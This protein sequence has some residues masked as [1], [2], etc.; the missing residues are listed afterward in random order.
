M[1]KLSSTKIEQRALN[2]LESIIDKHLTMS[3]QFNSQDKEMSW[4]G[5]IDIFKINNGNQSK[6]N[7]DDRVPVQIKGHIDDKQRYIIKD[8][9]NYSVSLEDLHVYSKEK[10]VMY[11]QIFLCNEQAEVFYTL[12]YPSKILDYL[13]KAENRHNQKSIN[14]PFSKLKKDP[15]TLYNVAKQFS[16]EGIKQ[17]SA[18]TPLV[19]DRIRK[20]DFDKIEYIKFSAVG[21]STPYE[22]LLRLSSGD[23]CFYGKTKD[24]KYERPIEWLDNSVF[25][26][27]NEVNQAVTVENESYYQKYES[28]ADSNGKKIITLSPNLKYNIAEHR[29]EFRAVSTLVNLYND[30][31][32]LLHL[33]KKKEFCI[34]GHNVPIP[35][36]ID[37]A[38]EDRLNFYI[39]LFMLFESI[40]FDL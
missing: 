29:M 14:I 17:G 36:S 13:D 22:A 31:R 7:F 10:G 26:L 25:C 30:A 34:A 37:K 23:I 9:I 12:L 35:D 15:D 3:Y 16:N 6:Q 2:A 32:F 21:V 28:Y 8:R 40:A 24:D 4:D 11:F 18:Y 27:N 1:A 5:Y 39:D 19:Q 20:D 33:S 38:F